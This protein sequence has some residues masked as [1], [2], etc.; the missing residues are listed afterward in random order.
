M[1]VKVMSDLHIENCCAYQVYP[2]GE[3]DVLILAGDILNAKHFKTDG[4]KKEVYM[5]FLNTCSNNYKKVIYV[6]G[7][8]EYYGYN[9][10]STVRVLKNNLP[11]NI[12]LLENE[13]V[14][15]E[16]WNFVGFTFWTNFRNEDPLQMFD[17]QR[18]MNDYKVIRIGSNYRKLNPSDTLAFNKNSFKFLQN[19]LKLVEGDL[20][21]I[22]HHAPSSN[23]IPEFY[24]DSDVN[25]AYCNELDNFIADNPK[26]KY[27]AHGHCHQFF[28]YVIEQCRVICNPYGYPGQST[29]FSEELE[30]II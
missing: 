2:V 19:A 26:I 1:K 18:M 16:G 5:N 12:S 8:H 30:L 6:M 22:S 24:K 11:S 29:G 25:G 15:Y 9:Y 14:H 20:F 13:I 4:Y 28:D 23:S 3:G 27:W 7:N 21:I 10:E 17:A